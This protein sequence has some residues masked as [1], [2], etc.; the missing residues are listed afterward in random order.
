MLIG[1]IRFC[2]PSGSRLP[3]TKATSAARE[4]AGHLAHRVAQHD[5]DVGGHGCIGAAAHE[6]DSALA[7]QFGDRS[8]ALRMARHDHGQR[9]R[10]KPARR[11][12][13]ENQRLLAVAGGGGDPHGARVAE[14]RPELPA[15]RFR[16]VRS[17]GVE[18]QVA[19]DHRERRAQGGESRG[20]G[21]RLRRD[22]RQR[23]RASAATRRERERIRARIVPTCAR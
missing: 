13:V 3:P 12:R 2:P 17:P 11:E 18:F 1:S 23:A 20:I 8:E 5:V 10:R 9:A 16:A 14:T 7:Q 22:A 19:G 4:I 21:L 15:Q 6:W